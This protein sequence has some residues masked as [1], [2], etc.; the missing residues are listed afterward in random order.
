MPSIG[1]D[2][3]KPERKRTCTRNR[4]RCQI[5]VPISRSTK[6]L[7]PSGEETGRPRTPTQRPNGLSGAVHIKETYCS[8]RPPKEA[9]GSPRSDPPNPTAPEGAEKRP[10]G[11]KRPYAAAREP[12]RLKSKPA[13]RQRRRKR[14][15]AREAPRAGH[16]PGNVASATTTRLGLTT[17]PAL[18][19]LRGHPSR[20]EYEPGGER[21]RDWK[22]QE[23]EIRK[24]E[25]RTAATLAGLR[26]C[27]ASAAVRIAGQGPA[28]RQRCKGCTEE[29]A[30]AEGKAKAKERRSKTAHAKKNAS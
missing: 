24:P 10:N 15:G 2:Y 23:K 19:G 5:P 1:T 18:P 20:I 17:W 22:S 25:T 8:K 30:K 27:Y 6:D 9:A 13:S 4:Q 14:R 26:P 28:R 3:Q 7:D 11:R 21:E 29:K 16:M 12:D